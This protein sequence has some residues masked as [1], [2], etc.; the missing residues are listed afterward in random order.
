VNVIVLVFIAYLM[1]GNFLVNG[2]LHLLMGLLG[3]RFVKRPKTVTQKQYDKV[4]AGPL[5]SSAV[6][7][8]V[9]GL[10]Q[11]AAVLILLASAS[12]STQMR[13]GRRRSA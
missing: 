2:L 9:Y 6:F 7:N 12:S 1:A 8:T 10:G 13:R 4:Y 11:L 5:F 3:R